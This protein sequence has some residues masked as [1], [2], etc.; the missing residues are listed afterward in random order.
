MIENVEEIISTMGFPIAVCTYLFWERQ[1]TTKEMIKV[2]RELHLAICKI[3][4]GKE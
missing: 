2:L 1:T 4:G 3:E